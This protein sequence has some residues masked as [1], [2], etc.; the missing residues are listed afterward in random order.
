MGPLR[1]K[2]LFAAAVSVLAFAAAAQAAPP[3]KPAKPAPPPI[4]ATY[5]DLNW[6]LIGPY[7]GGWG[8]MV[9]GVPSRPD[10]FLFGAAGGGVWRTDDAGRTWRPMFDQGPAAPVGAI[11]IAPS[12]PDVI[13]IGTGQV[14]P[15]YDIQAGMGAFRSGDGGKTW[16]PIGLKDTRYIGKIW[17]SPTDPNT[18]LVGAQGHFFGSSAERGVF[19]STDGGKTWT[20][21][22]KINDETGVVDIAADPKDPTVLIAA[23]WQARQYPWQSYFTRAAGPG[24]ALYK[25]VDGG[26]SWKK[27]GGEGW[28]TGD[29]GRISVATTRTAKGLRIYATVDGQDQSGLWR[30]D[31]GGAHWTRANPERAFVSYYS[32]RIV[33]APDDPDVIYTVG[34][35]V[36]RCD[37]A[38]ASCEIWKGAPGGDDYHYVWINPAHPDH[39][40]TASDQGTVVS[41]DGGKTWSSWYNQPTAQVYHLASDNQFPYWIYT[42]QQD[43]GT[44]G[45]ASRSDYGSLSYR[46][47]R[48]VGG[49]ERAYDIPDPNDPMIVY[50]SGLGG[51]V[52]RWDARTGQVQDISAWP[53]SSYGARPTTV[54]HHYNWVTPMVT[55]RTGPTTLFLGGEVLFASKDGG[56]N[57]A[58]ISPDLVGK[59]QGAKTSPLNCDGNPSNSEAF[60]CGFGTITQIAPSPRH[61]EEIWIGTD[62]GLIQLTR[63]G[64]HHWAEI[65]PPAVAKWTRIDTVEVSA[66]EDGVAYVTADAQRL[67][68]FQPHVFATR[69]YGRTWRDIS[70]NLPRDHIASVVRSDPVKPGLLYAGSDNDTWVSF[71]DGASW[72]TLQHNLPNA[73]VRD[74]MVHENDLVAATQGRAIWILDDVSPLRQITPATSA[75]A[76]HLFA[77]AMAMRV[78]PDNNKDTPLP[79][80]E[81]VGKNPPAGAVIDY[82]L[83]KDAKGEVSLDILDAS[84]AVVRSLSSADRD[85]K[86]KA[87]R[88]F[89]D[90]WLKPAQPLSR[91]A[92]MHRVVWSLRWPRPP[93]ISFDYSIAAVF[94]EDTPLSPDGPWAAPGDYTVVLKVDGKEAGRAPLKIAED[95]RVKVTTADLQASLELS[96]RIAGEL[97]KSRQGY[98]ETQAAR[99][100]LAAL[101]KTL[102]ADPKRAALAKKVGDLS[103]RIGGASFEKD[104]GVLAS[105]EGGLEGVDAAPT[106]AQRAVFEETSAS[107][108]KAW[109]SWTAL[110]DGDLKTLNAE[111]RKAGLKP[112]TFPAADQMK[113]EPSPGGQEL[114]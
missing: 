50:G 85:E 62:S 29:L 35:S 47:W 66:L 23:A 63:D 11:A 18:L 101:S 107:I 39:F 58:I 59:G 112:V 71:D 73:W 44:I 93:A 55:S 33:V 17:I 100:Q 12:D 22:L 109:A 5:A 32:S 97:G 49:D 10:S 106:G 81:P 4:E 87:E 102:S 41:V 34:Q 3:P 20:Q 74:L 78:H 14:E 113:I 19:R 110:R 13:Y 75:E 90:T 69:D 36:R 68:D 114:P 88:Y 27:L 25:S 52:S 72:H 9:E 76:A 24:S 21:A 45:I 43:S 98:G 38:G 103:A 1:T 8:E 79:P 42:G 53:I 95:P 56:Q 46:D 86:A 57:W 70:S 111:L 89:A 96:R 15:R 28:P 82:W 54:K 80:E 108:D 77:P 60:A 104:N 7:R 64:G 67:D 99:S 48:P 61:A 37:K 30:S 51:H 16:T 31:D 40:A 94:G 84:G 2:L 92:G 105:V 65:T 6:R 26:I 91:K 83:G